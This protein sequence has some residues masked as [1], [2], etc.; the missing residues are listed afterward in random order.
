MKRLFLPIALS[1]LAGGFASAQTASPPVTTPPQPSQSMPSQ[2]DTAHQMTHPSD[3]SNMSM[4]DKQSAMK[5]CVSQ[6]LQKNPGMS[7]D[8]AKSACKAEMKSHQ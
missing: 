6:Q 8:D 5:S 7:H 3:D 4:S 2:D 1:L